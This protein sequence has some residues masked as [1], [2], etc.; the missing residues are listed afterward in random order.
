VLCTPGGEDAAPGSGAAATTAAGAKAAA[1][2]HA[3]S[4]RAGRY[5]AARTPITPA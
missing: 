2:P 5:G 1:A 4:G 3:G